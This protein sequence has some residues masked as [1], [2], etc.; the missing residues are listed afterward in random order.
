MRLDELARQIGAELAGDGAIEINSVA[1]LEEAHAGQVAFLS[2][3]KYQK[4]L[5]TTKASAVIVVSRIRSDHV[6]LLKAE[7][8]YYA[9]SQAVVLLHG[10]RKHPHQ[11]VH[12]DAHVDAT[13]SIGPSTVIYPG[14]YVGPRARIGSDCVIY[15][16]ATI[17]DDT[18]IGDRVI[19]HACAVI[20]Q[21]GF[22]FATH[23]G[24][25]HKIPQVGNVILEDDVEIGSSCVIARA[26]LGS[27][28]IGK[29]TKIDALV[30]IGHGTKV[31]EH[32]LLV[33]QV[34]IAGSAT[35]GHHVTMAGQVGVAG[36]LKIGDNVTIAAKA[37]VISDVEDR[38][39]L[40]GVPAMPASQARRV[41]ALWTQLPELFERLKAL[42]QEV[43]ELADSG[44]TP[45][46]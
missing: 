6:A 29:G 10:Y 33:A 1:T 36:H 34:G 23:K 28:I 5:E 41:Y 38:A 26:A 12:A 46:A 15:P 39:V 3:P 27:T 42:E 25:H 11:G 30:V 22:G 18:I 4:Q 32:G 40:I 31:G 21:D 14:A 16:N 7:D 17:Y 20:G 35:I 43:E 8:P 19:V 45:I 24:E 44:D 13:A 2:N 37:G 9:Y